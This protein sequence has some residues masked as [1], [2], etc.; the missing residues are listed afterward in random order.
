MTRPLHVMHVINNLPVGGA[1][2]FLVLLADAQRRQG[3][4]VE[5]VALT[6]PNPLAAALAARN[7]PFTCLGSG[8]LRDARVIVDLWRLLRRRKPHV[9]H[10]HLFYA[11][12]FGRLAARLAAVPVVV[13]TEHSTERAV[14]SGR[15]TVAMRLA[16]PLAMRIAAVS[17]SVANATVRR[18][19]LPTSRVEVIPNGIELE[20]WA[21]AEPVPRVALGVD[22]QAFLVGSVGRL[23]D[24]KGHDIL[25]D[26]IAAMQDPRVQVIVVG[27]GPRREALETQAAERGVAGAFHWLG[28]RTDVAAIL[29]SLDAFAQPSRFEGHSMALLEAMAAGRACV[30]SDLPELTDTLGDAGLRAAVGDPPALAARLGELRDDGALR[31]RLGR[32]ART[33]S[34]AYSIDVSA[35][36]YHDLYT[37]V[38]AAERGRSRS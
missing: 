9:V 36:R 13:S 25:I 14:L 24:A 27:D 1:E 26:A 5:V 30:V 38:L 19:H 37:R 33:A 23:D 12:T 17:G 11:D 28:W 34:A 22:P 6:E 15:R 10:T 18:L 4:Q 3:L 31:A 35:A 8:S 20:P 7:V 29:V 32:A 16:A 2:R 21:A